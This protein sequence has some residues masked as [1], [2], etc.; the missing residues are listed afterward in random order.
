MD[1]KEKQTQT[2]EEGP[3]ENEAPAEPQKGE[4]PADPQENEAPAE[5]Q[6]GEALSESQE[7]EAPVEPQE[8]EAPAEP[9]E[10][11]APSE[12]QES[13]APVE[14]QENEAPAEPQGSEEPGKKAG[15]AVGRLLG[16]ILGRAA[17]V[18][19]VTLVIAAGG[20]FGV[21]Y[22]LAR[23]PSPTAQRLFVMSLR[24]TSAVGFIADIF[25][26]PE[27]IAQIEAGKGSE[28]VIETDTSLVTVQAE[29]PDDNGADAWGLVDEDG[30]GIIIDDVKGEGYSGF[31]MVVKDPSRVIMG[32]VTDDFGIRGYTVEEM[33]Q[34]FD[35]VAGTNAGGF[36]DIGGQGRS[37]TA[38][39]APAPASWGWTAIIS[40]MWA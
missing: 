26:S 6:E 16:R 20:V 38:A 29:E 19:L 33:V 22:I 23:G 5:P 13:E 11:E 32:S 8:G 36:V 10:G 39:G 25:L 31:M 18:L 1:E 9:Q 35:A 3:Q 15:P 17:I 7:S 21:A 12:S 28:R 37:T 4:A 2:I 30:D 40:C 24:E 14:P 27:E 34:Y